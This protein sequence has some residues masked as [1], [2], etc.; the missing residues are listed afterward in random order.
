ME[1]AQNSQFD[2]FD[3]HNPKIANLK[4]MIQMF[5]N[6][7]FDKCFTEAKGVDF[8]IKLTLLA[9]FILNSQKFHNV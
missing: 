4:K 8:D 9:N 3:A 7:S 1:I 6:K 2:H 5:S